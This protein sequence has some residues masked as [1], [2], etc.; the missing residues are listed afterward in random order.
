MDSNLLSHDPNLEVQGFDLISTD[1][2]SNVKRGGVCI[3]HKNH[4]P[5]KLININFLHECLTIELNIKSKLCVLVALYRSLS[6]SH[7]EFSSFITNLEST[8]QAITLR[9]P[10]LTTVLGDFNTKDKLWFNQHNTSYEGSTLNYLIAQYG[11]TQILHEPIHI[12]ESSVSCINLVFT[13]QENIV[14]NSGVD[15]SLHPNCHHQ[16]VF[17]NFN[18]KIYYPSPY[19]RLIWKYEKAKADLI[20][21]VI[22]DFDW[23]N[24][25]SLIGINDQVALVNE[26]TVNIMSNFI[27]NETMIFDYRDP[28]WLNENIKNMINYKIAI[29]EKLIHH[30]N[31]HLK[32]HLHYFQDLL[33]TKIE[34]AKRKY[35]EN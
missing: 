3:C 33:P 20:K 26:T 10:F 6:Q 22:R 29:Y 1:H 2:L 14:T 18:L 35:F 25:L 7:N 11:L 9:N 15:S 21:R 31:S 24:K 8:L 28:P 12:L 23:E 32:L 4:L 19:E 13:F 27:P 17:S 34:Q 30:N 5:L 16:I